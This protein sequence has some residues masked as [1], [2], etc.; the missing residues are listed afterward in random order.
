MPGHSP[1]PDPL[2]RVGDSISFLLPAN[3]A[4]YTRLTPCGR[5]CTS[6]PAFM[7]P[8]AKALSNA[9]IASTLMAL[10]PVSLLPFS[11]FVLKEPVGLRA[12]AGTLLAVGGV[13]ALL[14]V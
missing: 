6:H 9:W 11:H 13:A 14:L 7:R 12:V 3:E 10:V 4:L 2:H 1:T 5:I 8:C